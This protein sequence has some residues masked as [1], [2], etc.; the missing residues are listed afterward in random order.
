MGLA[1]LLSQLESDSENLKNKWW[2]DL[3]VSTLLSGSNS[4]YFEKKTPHQIIWGNDSD[5]LLFLQSL[6]VPVPKTKIEIQTN[7]TSIEECINRTKPNT[8]NTGVNDISQIYQYIKW[9]N[10]SKLA[11]WGSDEGFFF[12]FQKTTN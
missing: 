11:Y 2:E 8:I 6:G 12:A 3:L 9:Q 5:V 1:A 7:I 4:S 10:M